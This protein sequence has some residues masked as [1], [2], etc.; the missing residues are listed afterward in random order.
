MTNFHV[1]AGSIVVGVDGSEDAARAVSWAAVQADLENRPLALVHTAEQILLLG[2]GWLD[3]QGVDRVRLD[4]AVNRAA[5]AVLAHACERAREAAPE[6][7][8]TTH[9]VREDARDAL[10]DISADAHLVVVGSRGLGPVR[11]AVLGSVSASVAKRADCPVVVCRPTGAGGA[12][13]TGVV[14]GVDGTAGSVDVLEFAFAQASLHRA[15]LTVMHCFWDVRAATNGPGPVPADGG[16]PSAESD[17]RL[18]LAECVAGL[19]EKYPDVA[20]S[21]ELARGLVDECLADRSPDAGL[22][23]VGRT[24]PTGWARFLHSSCALAVLERAH[25]TVA[26]VPEPV[27]GEEH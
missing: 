15:P 7:E 2:S 11:S 24:A 17:L 18:L 20:V 16:N 14:V 13:A 4:A 26:V 21:A 9:L 8:V 23:V 3:A 19:A 25:T 10:V 12:P 6:I 5:E 27:V 1:P 22:L